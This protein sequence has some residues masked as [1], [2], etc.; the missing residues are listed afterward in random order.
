M[1]R[2]ATL[3]SLRTLVVMTTLPSPSPPSVMSQA[4]SQLLNESIASAAVAIDMNFVFIL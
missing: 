1:A 4:S 3:T 2:E